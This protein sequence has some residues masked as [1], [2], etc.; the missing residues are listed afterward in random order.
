MDCV[1]EEGRLGLGG[2]FWLRRRLG[3]I[4]T[5]FRLDL[6]CGLNLSLMTDEKTWHRCENGGRSQEG[7]RPVVPC[8]RGANSS[9]T[10][11]WRTGVSQLVTKRNQ[12]SNQRKGYE[13]TM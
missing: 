1:G 5:R 2:R 3:F 13:E 8:G 4:G 12:A 6:D 9:Y 11:N 7:N 10:R